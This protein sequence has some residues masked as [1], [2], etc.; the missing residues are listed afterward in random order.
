MKKYLNLCEKIEQ[1]AAKIYRELAEKEDIPDEL[2][3]ILHQLARD[4]EDHAMQ[5]SFATRFSE[6]TVL[7][8]K[9]YAPAEAQNLLN[10]VHFL[11]DKVA[12]TPMS[13]NQSLDM[14]LELERDF[15]KIHLGASS[16]FANENIGKMFSALAG[17]EQVHVEKLVAACARFRRPQ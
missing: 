10:R 7:L 5:L 13:L 2:R 4:E 11:S 12:N 17:D 1:T 3:K 15:C 6:G 14:A 9:N 16:D 8:K